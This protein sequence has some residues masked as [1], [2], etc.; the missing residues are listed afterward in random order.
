MR[1]AGTRV[2][3]R[4]E[5]SQERARVRVAVDAMGGD[6][7]P[8]VLVRGAVE[9]ARRFPLEVI[10]VGAREQL[11][12]VL[13][14]ENAPENVRLHHA[15]EVVAMGAHPVEAVKKQKDS[16]I[17][18]AAKLVKEGAADALV[19][20]GSTG[21]AMA[22]SLLTWGRIP[23]IERPA[24]STLLPTKRGICILLDAGAQVDCRPKHLHQFALMGSLYAERVLEIDPPKVG[25]LSNGE[26]EG[27][28]S[29]V[30]R[31]AYALLKSERSLHFIGNI[32]GRDILP[33]KADVVVCDGFVGNVVLKFA[34]G[35]GASFIEFLKEA[36]RRNALTAL[37]GMLLRTAFKELR[38]KMD[39]AEY[40]GAPLLGV[41]GVCIIS[42]GSSDEKAIMNAVRVAHESVTAGVVDAIAARILE[43]GR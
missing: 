41:Q 17:V 42:H 25:L 38:K 34:E 37:G 23:G 14:R 27:K 3:E 19:S 43:N 2:K 39:Y 35:M 21:A 13:E 6:R 18:V 26:E 1:K 20:A 24:I 30:V 32:E 28:G 29:E 22:C 16:S 9:A 33:G 10:L 36:V 7:G 8:E 15:S 11:E 31:E 40:G 5:G 4:F 12:P